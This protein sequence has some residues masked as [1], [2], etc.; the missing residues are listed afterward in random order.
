[1]KEE[2][3]ETLRKLL[4]NSREDL[5][6]EVSEQVSEAAEQQEKVRRGPGQGTL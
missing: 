5:L 4:L 3:R 1:M 2:I 6:A